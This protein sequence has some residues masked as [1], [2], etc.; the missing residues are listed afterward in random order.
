MKEE[1]SFPSSTSFQSRPLFSQFLKSS[2]EGKGAERRGG[3][4]SSPAS[5]VEFRRQN[6][7]L[8][9]PLSTSSIFLLSVY[10]LA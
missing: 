3:F 5:E 8:F 7:I 1:A 10:H 6:A 4:L 2:S 9:W